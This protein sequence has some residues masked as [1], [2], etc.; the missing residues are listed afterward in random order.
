MAD[1][2]KIKQA[3]MVYK[4]LCKALDSKKWKYQDHPEDMV[5]TFT[6]A[7]DDIPME[8]VVFIDSDRQ[9][10]RMLS[11]LPFKF[12]EDNR[13]DGAVATSYINYKLADGSFDYDYSTGEVT[14]RLTA[15]FIDSLIS[16][17]LLLYMVAC[18]CYT[19]DEYND[20]LLMVAKGML[21][22]EQFISLDK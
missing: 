5:V 17:D 7:G 11:R 12:P 6:S 13:V 16:E 4:T 21:P 10:V 18:A 14:F 19:V 3:Q 2:N 1:E 22:I 9:L 20:K 8:F 15:T